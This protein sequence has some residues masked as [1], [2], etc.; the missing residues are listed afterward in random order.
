MHFVLVALSTEQIRV[1]HQRDVAALDEPV[2][3]NKEDGHNPADYEQ[4]ARNAEYYH[5]SACC[6]DDDSPSALGCPKAPSF[7]VRFITMSIAV[8]CA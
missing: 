4:L 2:R 1:L 5:R 8:W 3:P 6:R 7:L